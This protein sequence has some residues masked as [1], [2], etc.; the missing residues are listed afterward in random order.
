M[1]MDQALC[2]WPDTS[3]IYS[4][5]FHNKEKITEKL[6]PYLYMVKVDVM[7]MGH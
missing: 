5:I 2:H 6:F 4:S 3:V 1:P 7:L